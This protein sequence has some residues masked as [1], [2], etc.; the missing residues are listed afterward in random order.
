[1]LSKVANKREHGKDDEVML[2]FALEEYREK[3]AR[4]EDR[5]EPFNTA[6]L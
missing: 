4:A 1:M 6:I 3:Y 5:F 2:G